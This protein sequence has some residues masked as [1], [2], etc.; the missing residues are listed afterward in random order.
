MPSPRAQLAS[1][2]PQSILDSYC[3]PFWATAAFSGAADTTPMELSALGVHIDRCNG[4]RGAMF[5][6]RCVVDAV[7][8]FVAPRFV[9]T[10]VAVGLVFGV[11]SL[12][13]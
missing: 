3:T 9:T 5:G 10:L 7:H 1:A 8:A 12:I 4:S 6:L 13:V 2:A 11:L